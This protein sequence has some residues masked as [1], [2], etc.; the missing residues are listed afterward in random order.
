MEFYT[1]IPNFLENGDVPCAETDPDAFFADEP[2]EGILAYRPVYSL[3][4]QAKKVCAECPY[5]IAC[6]QY[7]LKVPQIQGI[8]GGTTERDRMGIRR[9]T[10]DMRITYNNRHR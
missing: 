10:R 9:G 2:R 6:L 5:R 1:D 8:W 7:A 3:E 4:N